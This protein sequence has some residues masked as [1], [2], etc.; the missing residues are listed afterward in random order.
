MIVYV[1]HVTM[2]VYVVYVTV[3]VHVVYVTM[4]VHVVHVTNLPLLPLQLLP[5]ASN[6]GL[7]LYLSHP[8][9]LL[10]RPPHVCVLV[11]VCVRRLRPPGPRPVC[12]WTFCAQLYG[13][14]EGVQGGPCPCCAH[15]QLLADEGAATKQTTMTMMMMKKTTT[16]T[17]MQMKMKKR[18]GLM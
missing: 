7:D 17:M 5:Q 11:C 4:I 18:R 16:M 14:D 6:A 10:S 1:V 13:R 8:S 2:I 9:P 15:A 3:I 12:P